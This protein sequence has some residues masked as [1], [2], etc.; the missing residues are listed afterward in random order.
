MEGARRLLAGAAI[1][2]AATWAVATLVDRCLGKKDAEVG[3]HT[4]TFIAN[5][6]GRF[7]EA[8]A[9]S[10]R[11]TTVSGHHVVAP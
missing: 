10:S 9:G 3:S 8:M 4:S 1:G 5:R 11:R 6:H 7:F 2:V